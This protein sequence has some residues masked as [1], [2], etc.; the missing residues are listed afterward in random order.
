[1]SVI[2]RHTSTITSNEDQYDDLLTFDNNNQDAIATV[3]DA[4]DLQ[5]A[6]FISTDLNNSRISGITANV[7]QSGRIIIKISNPIT[8]DE[9]FH[10][11]LFT[12]NN[13]Y[14]GLHLTCPDKSPKGK[15][16]YI[17]NIQVLISCGKEDSKYIITNLI[18]TLIYYFSY[19]TRQDGVSLPRYVSE[20]INCCL[21][22]AR[23]HELTHLIDTLSELK[24]KFMK[25]T[26]YKCS[27]N[28]NRF[29]H[30]KKII[31]FILI[32]KNN[33]NENDGVVLLN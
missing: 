18:D 14:G 31:V 27:K 26:P 4:L 24:T 6:Q 25:Y 30:K 2:R 1:M 32:N 23:A 7:E 10:F 11:S 33:L 9:F 5:M 28:D 21:P 17:A 20:F 15:K 19:K 12:K 3:Y 22:S 29:H 8:H 13:R 16:I